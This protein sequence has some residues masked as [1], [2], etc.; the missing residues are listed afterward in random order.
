MII[1]PLLY[2]R[3]M[4]YLNTLPPSTE[5]GGDL[6]FLLEKYY[7][8]ISSRYNCLVK[9]LRQTDPDYTS[10]LASSRVRKLV[11]VNKPDH[12]TLAVVKLP[13]D[14]GRVRGEFTICYDRV[15]LKNF[16]NID[17][18][19]LSHRRHKEMVINY[20]RWVSAVKHGKGA[21]TTLLHRTLGYKFGKTFTY[22]GQMIFEDGNKHPLITGTKPLALIVPTLDQI[23]QGWKHMA[24][25][26]KPNEV[27]EGKDYQTL[28]IHLRLV[29][30]NHA[31][32]QDG[33]V[34]IQIQLRY[35]LQSYQRLKE[36]KVYHD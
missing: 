32:I 1:N 36:G 8:H 16:F 24:N 23:E 6:R 26:D 11:S 18:V 12:N 5:A 20:D 2:Q 19:I 7:T 30:S 28:N 29:S 22:D 34:L 27:E 4:A 3:D 9:G 17:E 14:K 31:F 21:L 35:P 15:D 25:I 33:E 10:R 13:E